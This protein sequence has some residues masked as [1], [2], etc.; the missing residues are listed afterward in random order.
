MRLC[1]S[2]TK[3]KIGTIPL[4]VLIWKLFLFK[5]YTIP[6]VHV[7][8]VRNDS[9]QGL[10]VFYPSIISFPGSCSVNSYSFFFFLSFRFVTSAWVT[11]SR[12]GLIAS[13]L[14]TYSCIWTKKGKKNRAHTIFT[15]NMHFS[16]LSVRRRFN[17][18]IR[19]STR[20]EGYLSQ[21]KDD[22][23]STKCVSYP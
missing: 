20:N 5:F 12:N 9:H 1:R 8:K 16:C 4:I 2:G 11:T 10:V 17:I 18:L 6:E 19:L 22:R 14:T 15:L 13:N 7:L 21:R 23:R 3:E